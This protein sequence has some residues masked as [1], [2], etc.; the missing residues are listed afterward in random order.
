MYSCL[1]LIDMYRE[2]TLML[3]NVSTS[4]PRF[5]L[6]LHLISKNVDEEYPN[7]PC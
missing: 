4:V 3:S 2:D 5:V 7:F 1:M 6:E